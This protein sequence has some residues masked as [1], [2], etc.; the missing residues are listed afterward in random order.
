[1]YF[2]LSEVA[3]WLFSLEGRHAVSQLGTVVKWYAVDSTPFQPNPP[4]SPI[5]PVLPHSHF[6]FASLTDLRSTCAFI[7]STLALRQR[8]IK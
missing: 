6:S 5:L 3:A 8:R 2:S 1:M 7:Q 4:F